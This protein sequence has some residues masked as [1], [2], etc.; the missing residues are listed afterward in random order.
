MANTYQA[1]VRRRTR[2]L[3]ADMVLRQRRFRIYARPKTG[4]A[5]WELD[6]KLYTEAEADETTGGPH[7]KGS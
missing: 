7:E 4:K 5:V 2:P 1:R 6:G 3:F